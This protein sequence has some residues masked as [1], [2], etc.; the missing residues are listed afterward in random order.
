V[1]A[2]SR[3]FRYVNLIGATLDDAR[4]IMIQGES[5]I[6]AVCP[7]H[8]RPR[9]VDRQL[10]WPNGSR[11]LIFT[12]D[13]PERLRGKQHEKL[14]A[15]EI[16]AWRYPES[17]DQAQLGLRL[18]SS[19]QAVVTTT[20]RPTPMVKALMRDPA[21]VITGGDTYA[22][23][24][25]LAGTFYST[26]IRKYEGTRLG[27]QELNAELLED[28]PG[29][30]W[31]RAQ[32]DAS[33]VTEAPAMRRIV[34]AVDPPVT[35]RE[36]SDEAGII[37]C[38]RSLDGAF[39]VLDDVSLRASPEAWAR[40]AVRLYHDRKADRLVAEVNNGGD[41]VELTIRT[42]DQN[43]SYKAVTASRGKMIRAEPIAALYEQGR[44]HHV[45]SFPQLEDQMCD[46]D[47][48]TSPYSPDRMDALVW[49]LTELSDESGLGVFNFY[50]DLAGKQVQPPA[51]TLLPS[52]FTTTQTGFPGAP[53][54]GLSR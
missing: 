5:G 26:I 22:N 19:P 32:I 47:P 41:M 17:W 23:R 48:L 10:R 2:W 16:A 24:A 52:S 34:V 29:A 11:S 51:G 53:T 18:G 49:A 12:A 42:V 25:N 38:G 44:V 21:T 1:R 8:E 27:R 54:K 30:L 6:L 20:P 31:Q 50:R 13:E 40:A 14:W 43:V 46:Y 4:D 45:G 3:K 35:N 36:D 37:A 7:N 28:N 9:Y 33:R 15:D 39:Y